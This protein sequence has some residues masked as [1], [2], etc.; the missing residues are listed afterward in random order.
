MLYEIGD[1]G[2]YL[3]PDVTCDF[4]DVRIES[5]ADG[6]VRVF[7]AKGRAPS[8]TYKVS[9]TQHEG[10]RC[11]GM[12]VIVGIEAAAKA[13]RTGEAILARTRALLAQQ[14][15]PDFYAASIELFGNEGLYGPHSRLGAA[16]EVMVRVVVDHPDKTAL[17]LFAR[18]ITPAGTSW[19]PGTTMPS[20]GRPSPSPLVKPFAFLLDKS[21]VPVRVRLGES[22]IPVEIVTGERSQMAAP[23]APPAAWTDPPGELLV[24]VPL[25]K[26][27]WGR[28]GDKG[29]LSNIGL[30]ARQ[31][32]WLPLLW[33]RVTPQAVAFYFAHLPLTCPRCDARSGARARSTP[34]CR[35]DWRRNPRSTRRVWIL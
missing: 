19:S 1:P 9:A 16:R 21:R 17:E 6:K 22:V 5:D 28:S 14:G 8:G 18:E 23:V 12:M 25:V 27:A 10:F 31:P 20:G 30:I 2:S 34:A 11:A 33:A 3:L 4:R 32:Q 24:D 29:D 13:R 15:L 26:L 35:R 7:G